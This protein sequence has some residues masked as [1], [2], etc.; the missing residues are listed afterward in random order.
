MKDFQLQLDLA[1]GCIASDGEVAAVE[2]DC[3]K[4]ICIQR[5]VTAEDYHTSLQKTQ[6]KFQQDMTSLYDAVVSE[7]G[8]LQSDFNRQLDI[9]E[10][11]IELVVSDGVVDQ[12][13]LSFLRFVISAGRW[14]ANALRKAKPEWAQYIQDGFDTPLELRSK[15]MAKINEGI[16]A[17]N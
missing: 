7:L 4:S 2:L 17:H 16:Q 13:E 11:L 1:F 5:G 10:I 3:L 9:M 6:Q 14:D 15:V 12:G 8:E